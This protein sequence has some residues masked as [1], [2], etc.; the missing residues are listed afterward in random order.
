MPGLEQ[1]SQKQSQV[2]EQTNIL[3]KK[4]EGLHAK[5]ETLADGLSSVLRSSLPAEKAIEDSDRMKLVVLASTLE[6][7]SDSVGSASCKLEDIL[8]RLEI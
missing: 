1:K 8:D 4:L 3:E 5:I 6:G 2:V 7:F